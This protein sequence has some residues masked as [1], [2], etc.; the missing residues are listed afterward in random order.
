MDLSKTG[1]FIKE[2]RKKKN[3]T[4]EQLAEKLNVSFKTVSRWECGLGLP[5]VSTMV[6]LCELLSISL[7]ELL[8]GESIGEKEYMEK[9]ENELLELQK[10]KE[11]S[12]KRLLRTEIVLG[13]FSTVVFLCSIF[14]CIFTKDD[15][16]WK[17]LIPCLAFILFI[18]GIIFCLKIEQK[19]GY[20]VCAKC[21]EKF[22]PTFSQ[23]L[24][25]MHTNRTRYMKCPH[26]H[27]HSWCKKVIK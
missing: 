6:P 2:R 25:S 19:A 8:N 22:V 18:L 15:L 4:Q 14:Y 21:G 20:Y 5:D 11:E 24:W 12:D 17:I 13:L 16:V 27:Q 23:V 3:M 26:C 9:A 1:L 7:N 10:G